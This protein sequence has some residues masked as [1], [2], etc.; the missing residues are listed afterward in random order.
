MP[1]KRD[2][3]SSRV[4][5]EDAVIVV[6]R[7]VSGALLYHQHRGT[8]WNR[9]RHLPAS[10][11]HDRIVISSRKLGHL[12][13]FG[14]KSYLTVIGL[15]L[16]GCELKLLGK[17]LNRLLAHVR[18]ALGGDQD[19]RAIPGLNRYLAAV[20]VH[21]DDRGWANVVLLVG[22]HRRRESRPR[23]P[24]DERYDC[25]PPPAT[26]HED[27]VSRP[28]PAHHERWVNG[29]FMRGKTTRMSAPPPGARLAVA[30]PPWT[31]AIERTIARPRPVPGTMRERALSAR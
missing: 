28:P 23:H 13:R 18:R 30:S 22:A 19:L 29:S 9:D 3:G 12:E 20:D 15:N 16:V 1:F 24:G 10:T 7:K 21:V 25:S 2:A 27:I 8:A 6:D 4:R 5:D 31:R 26:A 14:W 11:D 17:L